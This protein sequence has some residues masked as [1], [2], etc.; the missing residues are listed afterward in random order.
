MMKITQ[1]ETFP[2]QVPINPARAIRSGRGYHTASPFLM[3]K[4]HTD[5]D[6]TGVG[7][8]SCTPVW[9]GEDNRTAAHFIQQILAPNLIGEDPTQIERLSR[10]MKRLLAN[11]PFTKAGI[12][13]ALW[14]ILGKVAG[15]PVYRLLGGAVRDFVTTKFSVSGLE[16]AQAAEVAAWAVAQGFRTMKV[17]VGI[18]PEQDVARVRAVR[19]AIGPAVRLGVDANG[20]WSPRVAIQT[21]RRLYDYNIYFAEQPVADVDIAWLADVRSQVEVPVMADESLYSVQDAMAL[22]RAGAADIFSVYVSKG[23]GIGAARQIAAVAEAAGLVCTVGSNLELGVASAAMI[24]LAM[25]TPAISAEEFPCDI[26]TPFF[27]ESDLLVESLPITAG[28]AAPSERPGL[29]VELDD[30]QLRHY[31]AA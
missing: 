17:K 5:A 2:V 18:D 3:L 20:G 30:D 25:A 13:M 6:I 10:L 27:Y 22:A 4:V 8:V 28:R 21:I 23:G 29:G 24:H 12:E 16:P 14:D 9:S 7:E 1:I 11:N 26:L 19:E 15:L 31:R